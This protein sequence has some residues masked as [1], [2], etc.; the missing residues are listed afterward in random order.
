MGPEA[1]VTLQLL[2]TDAG[3]RAG[4]QK[5]LFSIFTPLISASL[6]RVAGGSHWNTVESPA[7]NYRRYGSHSWGPRVV[8]RMLLWTLGENRRKLPRCHPDSE[9]PSSPCSLMPHFH[10]KVS[11]RIS[12]ASCQ[13]QQLHAAMPH[14]LCSHARSCHLHHC[15]SPVTYSTPYSPSLSSVCHETLQYSRVKA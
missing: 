12:I 2:P 6:Q 8:A 5:S 9:A 1:G 13:Y 7:S 11:A 14:H 3:W 10:R 15:S 4:L